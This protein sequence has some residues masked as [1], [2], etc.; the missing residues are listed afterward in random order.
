MSFH[1]MLPRKFFV[2]KT[3]AERFLS[4]VDSHVSLQVRDAAECFTALCA[5]E[6]LFSR[7]SPQVLFHMS[8]AAKSSP[9]LGTAERL[10]KF[11]T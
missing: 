11:V 6:G 8:T 1:V 7:V 10:L 9:T 5:T 4:G 3:A 2:T